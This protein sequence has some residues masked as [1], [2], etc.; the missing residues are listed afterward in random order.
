MPSSE[1]RRLVHGEPAEKKYHRN[2]SDPCSAK[3]CQGSMMFP[4]DFDIF[5]PAASTTRSRHTTFR[6]GVSPNTSV[7]TASNE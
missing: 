7:L 2:A 4:V 5:L 3:I 6:Y 1:T